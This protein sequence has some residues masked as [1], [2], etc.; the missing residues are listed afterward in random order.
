[1][2]TS[3]IVDLL[4]ELLQEDPRAIETL[5][6]VRVEC[7][8]SLREHPTLVV[9]AAETDTGEQV[10]TLSLRGILNAIA[11]IDGE[12]IIGEYE[13]DTNRLIRFWRRADYKAQQNN[14]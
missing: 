4:N 2:T 11:G 12:E 13:H 5:T 9:R 6:S 8:A 1:M 3:Q 7:A 10:Q 14:G